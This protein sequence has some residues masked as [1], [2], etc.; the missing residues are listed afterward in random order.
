MIEVTGCLITI[1]AM[2]CQ[3]AIAQQIRDQG[4]HYVLTLKENQGTLFEDVTASFAELPRD[5]EVQH[6]TAE[7]I[8]KGH[9]RLERRRAT[10]ITDPHVLAWIQAEHHWPGL[11][12]LAQIEA[13]RRFPDGTRE[14]QTRW[15]LLSTPLPAAQC[16]QAVRTHWGIENQLHWILDVAFG[17][18]QSRV[19]IG[20]GA[21][22]FALLRR[23]SLNV[24]TH[25]HT[26]KGGVKSRR[27]QAGWDLAYLLHLLTGLGD[28]PS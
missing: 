3:R 11:A 21:Q 18:D 24:I 10:V 13:K 1:D 12:A 7:Q 6:T 23:I 22:N 28:L 5:P 17:E 2:G 4:A 9:G 20:H 15:Y 27:L 14:T 26:K 25:D 19:R 16:N 8:S